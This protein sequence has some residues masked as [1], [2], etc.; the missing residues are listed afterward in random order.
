MSRNAALLSI[1]VAC[2]VGAFFLVKTLPPSVAANATPVGKSVR[3]FG[4]I[5][6]GT[7]DDTAAVQKAVDAS[8]GTVLFPKGTYR[9]TA[10]IV[11]DLD[12]VG[13]TAV[14]GSGGAT[15]K[16]VGA[17]PALKFVG[18]HEGTASPPSV[19]PAVWDKQFTPR[20]EGLDIL[21]DHA[22]ADGIEADGTMQFTASLVTVRRCRHGIHLVKR[23][24]NVLISACHIYNGTGCGVYLDDVNL[25]QINIVG[26]H[27]SYC[28]GGGV[29]SRGGEVRNLHI[30]TCDIE[31]NMAKDGPPAANIFVD[32]TGGSTAEVAITGCT[33]QHANVP[34]SAN[35]RIH[36][37][38]IGPKKDSTAKWG[39]V[40]IGENVFS[41]VKVNLD[42][43]SCR[44]VTVTNNTFWMGYEANIQAENCEQIVIGPNLFERNPGY[45]YGTS[46]TTKNALS[47]EKCRD[48]TLTGLHVQGAYGADA[49]VSLTDC[50][51]FNV[52]G[53]TLL[54]CDGVAMKLVNPKNGRV[55][56]CLVRHDGEKNA[57]AV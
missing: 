42:L 17:G 24:R 4:A 13:T 1:A 40:T 56:G 25:H 35:I 53:C 32:C 20:V 21:G 6:D 57:E 33:I 54:D 22:D 12:K 10:P 8:A 15:L 5:G 49:A 37:L 48:C 2:A 51:R 52:A 39:H 34:G 14:V 26:S 47:F 31:S 23:N 28:G 55:G 27:I 9:I 19:K 36:G 11:V 44:G 46:K 43:K 45:D 16:M 38:G 29:V 50:E 7:V 30:G 41:D 18:T 3:D